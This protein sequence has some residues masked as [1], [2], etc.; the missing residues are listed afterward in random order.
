MNDYEVWA[1]GHEDI[2]KNCRAFNITDAAEMFACDHGHPNEANDTFVV[3]VLR[4][5]C[6]R[7]TKVR[8]WIEYEPVYRA[9]RVGDPREF[10]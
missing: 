9:V 6:K 7:A 2:K 4:K 3:K 5:G 10:S 8:V 1:E